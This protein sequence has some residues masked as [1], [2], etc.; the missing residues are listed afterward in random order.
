MKLWK[1]YETGSK[2]QEKDLNGKEVFVSAIDI[3][4]RLKKI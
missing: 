2:V 3:L 1:I 4:N